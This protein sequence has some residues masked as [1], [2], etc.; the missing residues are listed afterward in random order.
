MCSP[1]GPTRCGPR[2][3]EFGTIGFRR[4]DRTYEVTTHRAEAYSPDSRKPVGRVRRRRRGRPLAA[5]LHRQRDGA[6]ADHRRAHARRSVRRRGGPGRACA[7]DAARRP[8]SRSPTTRSACCRAARFIA[9]YGLAPEPE[10]RD[11]VVALRDRLE[12]VSAER[13]RGEFD[14]LLVVEKPGTGLWFLV[15]TGLAAEFIP[16]LPALARR[17]GS[18]PPPQGR[19]GPHDRRRR[20]DPARPHPSPGRAVPRRGQAEDRDR[21]VRRACRSITTRSSALA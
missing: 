15:E 17:A 20:E 11:A 4:G 18:D 19:A 12:I 9:G 5:R 10:V 3:S 14:R 16:E 2:G 7:A 6:R 1:G 13:I 8:R 21:S